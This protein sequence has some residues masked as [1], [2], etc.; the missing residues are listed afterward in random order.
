MYNITNMTGNVRTRIARRIAPGR[1]SRTRVYRLLGRRLLPNKSRNITNAS[2][3]AHKVKLWADE[4]IGLIKIIRYGAEDPKIVAS[5]KV[6]EVKAPAAEEVVAV[7]ATIEELDD[8]DAN[9]VAQPHPSVEDLTAL[10]VDDDGPDDHT[11]YALPAEVVEGLKEEIGEVVTGDQVLE[12]SS[13]IPSDQELEEMPW[14][15][16]QQLAKVHGLK[17]RKKDKILDALSDMREGA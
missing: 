6:V 11:E 4:K 13:I 7:A 14:K 2:F 12:V 1:K 15:D 5:V 16:L 10:A 3:E 17:V 9:T 8:G